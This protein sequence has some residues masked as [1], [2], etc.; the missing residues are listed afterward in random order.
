MSLAV[1][2]DWRTF[3]VLHVTFMI[4]LSLP[5]ASSRLLQLTPLSLLTK[6]RSYCKPA[7]AYSIAWQRDQQEFVCL[8][9]SEKELFAVS[10]LYPHSESLVLKSPSRISLWH[11]TS[12]VDTWFSERWAFWSLGE[13]IQD[14]LRPSHL[15]R[16]DSNLVLNFYSP[17]AAPV[18]A[19]SFK[20]SVAIIGWSKSVLSSN[21]IRVSVAST[22]SC[23]QMRLG[24]T[25][26]VST[27]DQQF[28]CHNSEING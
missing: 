3:A 24:G 4:W 20:A 21:P 8:C 15:H 22:S 13:L 14:A 27:Y 19:W 16:P 11:R 6:V 25:S 17:S 12:R 7:I 2:G 1:P 23:K 18:M 5:S 26:A 28:H 10:L 9:R